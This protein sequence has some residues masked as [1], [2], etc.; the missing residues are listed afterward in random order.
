MLE[1]NLCGVMD[2]AA[3]PFVNAWFRIADTTIWDD[4]FSAFAK[5]YA[6]RKQDIVA[7]RRTLEPL[8]HKF[9]EARPSLTISASPTVVEI[10]SVA[11]KLWNTYG[12]F[13]LTKVLGQFDFLP[14]E[15]AKLSIGQAT[16]WLRKWGH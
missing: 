15:L 5:K 14:K 9:K 2:H 1:E 13:K 16:E 10:H 11:Q 6:I 12:V 7:S 3:P 8:L 4:D